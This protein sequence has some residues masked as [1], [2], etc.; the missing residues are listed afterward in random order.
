MKNNPQYQLQA[1][2]LDQLRIL[3]EKVERIAAALEKR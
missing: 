2:Y 3:N 1:D